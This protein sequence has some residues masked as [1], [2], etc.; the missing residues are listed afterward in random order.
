MLKNVQ[1]WV[2]SA[3]GAACLAAVAV[4]I[5][6]ASNNQGLRLRVNERAQLIARSATAALVYRQMV[7]ALAQLSVRNHDP[8]LQAVLARQ[9]LKVRVQPASVQSGA[10]RAPALQSGA[11]LAGV[12]HE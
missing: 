11:G 6:L 12:H 2:L 7:Q 9:G 5:L 4:N 1:F 8:R 10:P 3:L